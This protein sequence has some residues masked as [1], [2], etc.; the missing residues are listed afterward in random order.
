MITKLSTGQ[1]LSTTYSFRIESEG[2]VGDQHKQFHKAGFG[3][4]AP[5][6]REPAQLR[7]AGRA[8]DEQGYLM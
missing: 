7:S 2:V 5:K 1:R 3:F 6:K 4:G 8:G